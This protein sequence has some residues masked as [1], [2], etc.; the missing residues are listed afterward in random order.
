MANNRTNEISAV[1]SIKILARLD[2]CV[3]LLSQ[4]RYEA[5]G[6]S[7]CLTSRESGS[8]EQDADI[9]CIPKRGLLLSNEDEE[10]DTSSRGTHVVIIAKQ[11]AVL[12]EPLTWHGCEYE[13]RNLEY[14]V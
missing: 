2:V 14:E 10:A 5:A 8:I 1:T 12:Q 3:I 11:R 9:S 7:L 13:V 6:P 4:P